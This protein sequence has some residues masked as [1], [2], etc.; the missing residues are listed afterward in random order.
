MLGQ[1]ALAV[2]IGFDLPAD[3]MSRPFQAQ[4][5]TADATE[6]TA[7]RHQSPRLTTVHGVRG[8]PAQNGNCCSISGNC[9]VLIWLSEPLRVCVGAGC[10]TIWVTL[11]DVMVYA[12][13]PHPLIVTDIEATMGTVEMGSDCTIYLLDCLS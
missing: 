10:I 3:G 6:Q 7:D 4:I 9:R 13:E 5:Q 2:G 11:V 8:A 1:D 12:G